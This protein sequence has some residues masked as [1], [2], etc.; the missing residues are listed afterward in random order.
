MLGVL[1]PERRYFFVSDVHVP[2]DETDEPRAAKAVTE[3]WFAAW[4]TRNLASD[5]KVAN[6][7]SAPLTTISRLQKYLESDLCKNQ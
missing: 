3:C 2:R 4:A 7:H 5:V 6:S 1:V